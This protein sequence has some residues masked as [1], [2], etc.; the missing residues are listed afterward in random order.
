GR[1]RLSETPQPRRAMNGARRV[2]EFSLLAS[3]VIRDPLAQPTLVTPLRLETNT[4]P[5][6][7]AFGLRGRVPPASSRNSFGRTAVCGRP[8]PCPQSRGLLQR[9]R[10]RRQ[11]P[12]AVRLSP[13]SQVVVAAQL[14]ADRC[15]V[16][17]QM[18]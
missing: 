15:V 9:R 12:G 8:D 1:H 5:P 2:I 16:A 3:S 7:G 18:E 13:R 17:A 4:K 6:G 11:R 10:L 14:C